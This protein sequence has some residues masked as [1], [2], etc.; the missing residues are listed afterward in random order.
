[1]T[2]TTPFGVPMN[3]MLRD[4][5]ARTS[6]LG[7]NLFSQPIGFRQPIANTTKI[8]PASMQNPGLSEPPSFRQ[9]IA[10]TTKFN[11]SAHENLLQDSN[12]SSQSNDQ[13][14]REQ[15]GNDN[16]TDYDSDSE[17]EIDTQFH[18]LT[19]NSI[20]DYYGTE[21]TDLIDW[22]D[23]FENAWRV[24]KDAKTTDEDLRE[25]YKVAWLLSKLQGA[26]RDAYLAQTTAEQASFAT[27]T[28]MLRNT[29]FTRTTINMAAWELSQ[30]K[31][32]REESVDEFKHR[33]LKAINRAMPMAT[34]E[35]RKE[36]T[37]QE[38]VGKVRP[39]IMEALAMHDYASL[40]VAVGIAK[41]AE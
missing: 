6:L 12:P 5:S 8:N 9:D 25:S 18:V 11:A 20:S 24:S 36:R 10:N 1:M 27:S 29:F 32:G 7:N 35:I 15:V 16:P 30:L 23:A 41:K 26:A 14:R 19:T 21:S 28:K 33:L 3:E 40:D 34:P 2:S 39:N 17:D 38:F 31:Q 4:F 22:L 37:L 13:L